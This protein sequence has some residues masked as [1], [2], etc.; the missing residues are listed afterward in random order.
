MSKFKKIL[1]PKIYD[2]NKNLNIDEE[3]H[4]NKNI[5]LKISVSLFLRFC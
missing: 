4:E 2:G 3:K 1:D 5:F